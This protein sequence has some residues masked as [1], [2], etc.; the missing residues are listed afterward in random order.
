M[1]ISAPFLREGSAIAET[2]TLLQK[3]H[4]HF[5]R[6]LYQAWVFEGLVTDKKQ[7]QS[8]EKLPY[9]RRSL[10]HRKLKTRRNEKF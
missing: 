9:I 6:E 2:M 8:A 5:L 1:V 10:R 4:A 7:I 3:R